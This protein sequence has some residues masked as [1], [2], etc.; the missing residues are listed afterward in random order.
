MKHRNFFQIKNFS[1]PLDLFQNILNNILVS[2]REQEF[3]KHSEWAAIIFKNGD[4]IHQSYMSII[5]SKFKDYLIRGRAGSYKFNLD[6]I[7][8]H[9][10]HFFSSSNPYQNTSKIAEVKLALKQEA[11]ASAKNKKGRIID[12]EQIS[13]IGENEKYHFFNFF[14]FISSEE[15]ISLYEGMQ[16]KLAIDKK[17]YFVTVLDFDN[18]ESKLT[19]RSDFDFTFDF[20][21][22]KRKRIVIDLIWMIDKLSDRLDDYPVDKIPVSKLLSNN[23]TPSIIENINTIYQGHLDVPQS[24]SVQKCLNNDIT[25]IWGP[26]GTGKSTTI[27]YLL[28]EL[29]KLKERTLICSIANVAVDSILKITLQ[30]LRKY[31]SDTING[32]NINFRTGQIIRVGYSSDEMVNEN[33]DIKVESALSRSIHSKLKKIKS[34]LNEPDQNEDHKAELIA[35]RIDL[36]KQLENEKA[37]IYQDATLLFATASKAEIDTKLNNM[38]FDNLII[39]E[40]SM[41]SAPHLL[42][43]ARNANKRIVIAG[44]FRQLGPI[45]LAQS[46]LAYKWLHTDLFEFFGIDHK[47]DDFNHPSLTMINIQRRFHDSICQLINGPFYQ[48]QLQTA[49]NYKVLKLYK[50][51]P[52]KNLSVVYYNLASN[53]DY[54]CQRTKEQ[55]RYN[56]GSMEYIIQNILIPLRKHPLRTPFSIAI[57][58]PYN[59]QINRYKKLLPEK[60]KDN[61]FLSRIKFGTVH[62]FQGSEADL[63]IFDMVDSSDVKIGRLYGH[64]S[65]ERLI[66]VAISR[67]TGKL[68]FVGDIKTITQGLGYTNVSYKVRSVLHKIENQTQNN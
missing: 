52:E 54:Q 46:Y 15:N 36:I 56:E 49:T 23:W 61:D 42:A 7:N 8:E 28:L 11:L 22:G 37:R 63:V 29:F 50:Q 4:S 34:E 67:S 24:A 53:F 58:S 60:I 21:K 39:D 35:K 62:S 68:I 3:L 51:P 6:L 40:A 38:S 1:D 31:E 13:K 2:K 48:N 17:R 10:P 66:N 16:I 12:I 27:S 33:S 18:S 59:G 55:S 19:I 30:T 65:G 5:T 64:N 45:A 25:A 14:L 9:F 57:I 43:L 47:K 32:S 44:D 41:M 26:P 20:K